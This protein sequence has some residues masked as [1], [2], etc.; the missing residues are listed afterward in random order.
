MNKEKHIYNFDRLIHKAR[1]KCANDLAFSS[2]ENIN[3]K[4]HEISGKTIHVNISF[5]KFT[6]VRLLSYLCIIERYI[7]DIVNIKFQIYI[8][9]I[10]TLNGE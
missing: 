1:L 2:A 7:C 8:R 6:N 9:D 3:I 5:N 10:K 4:V